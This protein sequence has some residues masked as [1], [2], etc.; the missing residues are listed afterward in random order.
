MLALACPCKPAN[1]R[2]ADTTR[3]LHFIDAP[4]ESLCLAMRFRIRSSNGTPLEAYGVL[5]IATAINK[6]TDVMEHPQVFL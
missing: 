3:Y 2:T 4:F 1:A 6:K 5:C